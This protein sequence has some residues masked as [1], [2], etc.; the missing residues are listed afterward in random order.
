MEGRRSHQSAGPGLFTVKI[1]IG[2]IATTTALILGLVTASAKSSFDA[3][4][5]AVKKP[6]FDTACVLCCMSI[7]PK[8]L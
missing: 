5:S 2:L 7:S 4:D 8:F 3:V 1:G 6:P